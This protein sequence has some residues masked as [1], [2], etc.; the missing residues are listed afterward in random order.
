VVFGRGDVYDPKTA[1]PVK[2]GGF[3]LHP[4]GLH[5]Y[6]GAKDEEVIVQIIGMGP[7]KRP[8]WTKKESQSARADL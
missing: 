1:A 8:T 2:V 7:V 6:D 5:H 4:A 3:M